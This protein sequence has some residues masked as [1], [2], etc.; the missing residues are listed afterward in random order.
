MIAKVISWIKGAWSY[1]FWR[2]FL[3][4]LVFLVIVAVFN[5]KLNQ[6]SLQIS[7][8]INLLQENQQFSEDFLNNKKNY[9]FESEVKI[10]QYVSNFIARSVDDK[11]NAKV[12]YLHK[13]TI[14]NVKFFQS[15]L[16]VEVIEFDIGIQGKFM[17]ILSLAEKLKNSP[18]LIIWKNFAF[19]I[20]NYPTGEAQLVFY[21]F[22]KQE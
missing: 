10:N 8:K 15:Y 21:T 9:I 1:G 5:H 4:F 7:K 17:E 18:F 6:K 16:P 2:N 14:K 13:K 3:F 11:R 20:K 19:T 22:T 12:L